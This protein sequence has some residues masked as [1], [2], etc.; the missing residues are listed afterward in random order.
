MKLLLDECIPK[1]LK[2]ALLPLNAITVYEM[3]WGG[4]KDKA[5]TF[6]GKSAF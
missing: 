5:L 1:S 3:G 6:F 2:S 4:T